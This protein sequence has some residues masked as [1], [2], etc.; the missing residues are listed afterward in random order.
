MR[1]HISAG[2]T[3]WSFYLGWWEKKEKEKKQSNFSKTGGVRIHLGRAQGWKGQPVPDTAEHGDGGMNSLERSARGILNLVTILTKLWLRR[4]SGAKHEIKYPQQN[5]FGRLK[6]GLWP[7]R[8]FQLIVGSVLTFARRTGA[9]L[10]D[11]WV[12]FFPGQ[13]NDAATR[14]LMSACRLNN[15]SAPSAV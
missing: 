3:S 12:S 4:H 15:P 5:A 8:G 10:Q 2:L 7:Q 11:V 1:Q 9:E 13:N 6:D 14:L